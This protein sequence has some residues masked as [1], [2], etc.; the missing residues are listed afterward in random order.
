[1]LE[2]YCVKAKLE[3]GMDVLDLGCGWGSL[4][5]FLAKVSSLQSLAREE[6][7]SV[8]SEIPQLAH[9]LSLQLGDSEAP[10][11]L[12]SCRTRTNE[13]RGLHGRRADL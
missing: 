5:L 2:S 6:L 11:R 10:H 3:D 9:H 13:H 12:A 1:M 8:L 4:T 7:I